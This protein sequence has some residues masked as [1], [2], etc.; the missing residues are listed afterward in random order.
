MKNLKV[1]I[2]TSQ[3][4]NDNSTL[5]LP[6][7]KVL[8]FAWL[9]KPHHAHL[10]RIINLIDRKLIFTTNYITLVDTSPASRL[11]FVINQNEMQGA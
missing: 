9:T 1:A 11:Y 5:E 6:I 4:K 2:A 10:D 8:V 3:N 7:T